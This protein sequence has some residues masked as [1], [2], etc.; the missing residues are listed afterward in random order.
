MGDE[1]EKG[2]EDEEDDGEA[3]NEADGAAVVG[4]E[5]DSEGEEKKSEKAMVL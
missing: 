3:V 2:R 5:K 4:E 1:D